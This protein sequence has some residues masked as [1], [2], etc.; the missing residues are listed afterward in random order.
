ME[1]VGDLGKWVGKK[2]RAW[3]ADQAGAP[4]VSGVAEQAVK[5]TV[6]LCPPAR[7]QADRGSRR[8]ACSRGSWEAMI[9][10]KPG[11]KGCAGQS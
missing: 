10:M 7:M 3:V 6:Q 9:R 8:K 1:R 4:S 2:G 11:G 5:Q